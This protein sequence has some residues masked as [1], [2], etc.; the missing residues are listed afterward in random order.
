MDKSIILA[1]DFDGTLA[2]HRFPHIGPPVPDA[3]MW[4]HRYVGHYD[5]KLILWTMRCCEG[6]A[7]D[8][9]TPAIE[10]CRSHGIEFWGINEN[11]QQ[12]ES[13]WSTSGK[14]YAHVYIDDAAA[15]TPLVHPPHG[16]RLPYVN[17]NLVGPNVRDLILFY[18]GL[19]GLPPPD[20]E[21]L[22]ISSGPGVELPKPTLI[23]S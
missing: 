4:L 23:R 5:V 21:G 18:R 17:W 8:V 11:P 10:F 14:V 20:E 2:E 19:K 15:G 16:G 22:S 3:F 13:R 12:K 7:G 6:S 9:L 1:V